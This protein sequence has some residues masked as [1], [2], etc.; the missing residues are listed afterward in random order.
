[1]SLRLVAQGVAGPMYGQAFSLGVSDA[2]KEALG[3]LVPG[4]PLFI[5]SVCSLCGLAVSAPRSKGRVQVVG[6]LCCDGGLVVFLC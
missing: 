3:F 1:M 6:A 5:A 4:L 2:T